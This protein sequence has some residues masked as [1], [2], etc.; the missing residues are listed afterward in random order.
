MRIGVAP[1]RSHGATVGETIFL[2]DTSTAAL[3]NANTAAALAPL[4]SRFRGSTPSRPR[5]RTLPQRAVPRVSHPSNLRRARRARVRPSQRSEQRGTARDRPRGLHERRE[6]S[7]AIHRGGVRAPRRARAPDDGAERGGSRDGG[8][9][10]D[11]PSADGEASSASS[12][13][14]TARGRARV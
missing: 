8:D 13:D 3:A 10:A 1:S 14:M 9:D 6:G 11:D 7:R 5:R 4:D 12:E 2:P